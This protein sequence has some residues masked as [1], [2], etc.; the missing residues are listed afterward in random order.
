MDPGEAVS[1]S[2]DLKAGFTLTDPSGLGVKAWDVYSRPW[3]AWDD[4]PWTH[5]AGGAGGGH[6][7]AVVPLSP[8]DDVQYC[9][10]ADDAADN[11]AGTTYFRVSEPRDDTD[12][13]F[14]YSGG[15]STTQDAVAYMGTLHTTSEVGAKVTLPSVDGIY[16][17]GWLV[18]TGSSYPMQVQV[19]INGSPAWTVIQP[20]VSGPQE[21]LWMHLWQYTYT[22]SAPYTVE[23]V[24][25]EGTLGFDGVMFPMPPAEFPPLVGWKPQC[26]S[27]L[28]PA[29]PQGARDSRTQNPTGTLPRSWS[30]VPPLP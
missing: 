10:T 11:R 20:S 29:A 26:G 1:G 7:S 18:S 23:L 6:Q 27:P 9:V 4:S 13:A 19:R 8:G 15:W 12:A 24:L 22:G 28:A 5:V 17:E 25:L 2:A 16:E 3:S 14:A 21:W 30:W